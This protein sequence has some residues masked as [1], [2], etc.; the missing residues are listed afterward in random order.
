MSGPQENLTERRG[1]WQTMGAD[2]AAARVPALVGELIRHNRL[3]HEHNAPEIS[4]REY[5][6]LYKELEVLEERFPALRQPDSPTWRVGGQPIDGLEPFPHRVPMLSLGNAFSD[7]ELVEFDERLKRELA[8]RGEDPPEVL[9]YIVEP[10]LDGLAIELV[11]EDGVLTGAGTRGDG[12]VGED[13]THNIRT[14]K[15]VP[16]RLVGPAP[17]YLSVRGEVLYDLA[18]FQA[19]NE[20]RVARGDKAFENPRNAAAG[21]IRQLDPSI[22]A[23]RPLLFMAHSAGEGI[24]ADA[25][26]RHSLLLARLEALGFAV[27]PNNRCCHGIEEV[28]QAIAELGE[29]RQQL[30]YEIDGAVVKVDDLALQEVLGFV[31][32]SPRW[33]TAFKYPPPTVVT[34]LERVDFGVGRT[35]VVTPVAVL[36]PARV[37]G[38]TVRNATL[39][40]E[41]Q[42]TRVLGLREGDRV[43]LLRAGDVIPRVEAVVEEEGREARPPVAYPETCPVCGHA[44]VR[45]ENPKDPDKVTIRCPNALGCQAQ[46]EATLQHFSS[47]LAM[48]I[49]GLGEKLVRQLVERGL[50]GR[51]SDLY[52]QDTEVLAGLERMAKKSAEN[53]QAALERSKERP[54]RRVIYA[55]GIRMVGESTARDLAA[56]FLTIEALME[57]D[58]AAL[59]AV[60]GVGPEVAREILEFFSDERNRDEVR[61]LQAVGVAFTPEE[62]AEEVPPPPEDSPFLGKKVV[63]TGTLSSM[64]RSE[65]KQHIEA[66]GG[67]VVGSVSAKTDL[68][69]AGEAAGSKLAKATA[70]GVAVVDE[71]AFLAMLGQVAG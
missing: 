22:A 70:L 53:L 56:H 6:L 9:D 36:E 37:G 35:G 67:K 44:L 41:H 24:E 21:T 17:A 15:N 2:E 19:M 11:Y 43:V 30:P 42:M 57:A 7:E 13:V 71:E 61:Q 33:A 50:V 47:R 45:E 63:L 65:A 34:R 10:K 49:D 20:R 51:P 32:R 28:R 31:T 46:L 58:E 29:L 5:D 69:V 16:L 55:L 52:R 3:Y 14:V 1:R 12:R 62:P 26:P 54:L 27:N 4:D 23:R 8:R 64:G 39:H 59:L 60:S 25:A 40:N 68:L 48:D 38:V 66:A 18:G